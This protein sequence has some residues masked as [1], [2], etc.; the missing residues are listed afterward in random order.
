MES[1]SGVR[2]L[3]RP[4]YFFARGLSGYLADGGGPV[5]MVGPVRERPLGTLG[6]L[7]GGGDETGGREAGEKKKCKDG[8][9][10]SSAPEGSFLFKTLRFW[11]QA[12]V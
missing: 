12:P 9:V 7:E 2:V 1:R 10:K 4:S 3:P 6:T 8:T 11:R 5:E